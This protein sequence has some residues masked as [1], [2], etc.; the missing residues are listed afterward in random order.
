MRGVV[1]KKLRQYSRRNWVEY[2]RAI[3][4]WPFRARLRFAW[5]ILKPKKKPELRGE[6]K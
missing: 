5:Y 4:Q 3:E 6:R 1:A 2:V